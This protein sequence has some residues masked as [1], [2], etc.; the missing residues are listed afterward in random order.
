MLSQ[1]AVE[2]RE[3]VRPQPVRRRCLRSMLGWGAVVELAV[4]GCVG[5]PLAV[6]GR[7][8]LGEEGDRARA[9]SRFL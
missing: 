2:R 8:G 3:R 9:Q 4:V 5:L 1:R 7:V 6:T